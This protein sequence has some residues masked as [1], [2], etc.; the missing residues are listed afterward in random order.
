MSKS[1]K[2]KKNAGKNFY[3]INKQKVD[4]VNLK[5]LKILNR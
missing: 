5:K 4:L 1:N 3:R 2:K